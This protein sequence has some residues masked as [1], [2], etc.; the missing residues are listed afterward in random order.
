MTQRLVLIVLIKL[1]QLSLSWLELI[2]KIIGIV[3]EAD[4]LWRN[5]LMTS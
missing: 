1:S 2:L 5:V 4:I 3:L